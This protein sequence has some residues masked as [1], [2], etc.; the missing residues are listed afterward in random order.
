M[1]FLSDADADYAKSRKLHQMTGGKGTARCAAVLCGVALSN[2]G[3]HLHPLNTKAIE[4]SNTMNIKV[5]YNEKNSRKRQVQLAIG[6][7]R[8][9]QNYFNFIAEESHGVDICDGDTINW[10]QFLANY[11]A[12]NDIHVVYITEKPFDDNWFSHE[13]SSVSIITTHDWEAQFA[14]PSLRAYIIYQIAQSALSFEADLEEEME[15]N[16]THDRAQGCI[17]DFCGDKDDIKLGMV[18]GSICP[19]CR[20]T[21][22][23]YGV[24][25]RALVSIERILSCVRSEALGKPVLLNPNKAFIVMR[26]TQQD[27]NAH[28]YQY[29]IILALDALGI[30]H[31]RLD[32]TVQPAQILDQIK[33]EIS[34][35][36]FVIAKVDEQNL[37]VYYELGL[38]MG[39]EKDVLLISSNDLIINLPNDLKNW[40]CLT[41][42]AG[43]YEALKNN[44]IHFYRDNYHY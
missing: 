37:N 30:E 34:R 7:L 8:G 27:E 3:N 21:L 35:S 11:P 20:S 22:L 9:S 1:N 25:E 17:F 18:A 6:L 36:R 38:S 15:L 44:I 31:I 16:M 12:G 10:E 33:T 32:E 39:W 43:D 14:P 2:R 5:I 4:R 29:G 19:R 28:A 26:F 41:Y 24:S 42:P 13:S 40:E 23:Q